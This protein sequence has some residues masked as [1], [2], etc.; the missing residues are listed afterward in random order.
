MNS[1]EAL[2]AKLCPEGVDQKVLSDVATFN[3][4]STI[5]KADADQSG[6][7]PVIAGGRSPAYFH[8]EANRVGPTVVVAGSGA[9][10]GFVSYWEDPV[11]VSDAFS[12]DPDPEI[13]H[14]KYIYYLLRNRQGEIHDL[15]K[16]GGVPHVYGRDLAAFEIGVPPLE[17]QSEI[18]RILDTFAELEAE[19]EAELD[20][21]KKQY[22]YYRDQLLTFPEEGGVRWI[23]MSDLF[24]RNSGTPITAQRM[25]EI[26]SPSGT[27]TVFAAGNTVAQV[28]RDAIPQG[29]IYGGEAIMV[30][31]RG[32]IDFDFVD[33]D[34]TH[35][36]ELWSY[37]S[38][39]DEIN[40]KFVYYFLKN[41]VSE[42]RDLA[43]SK[44]V[45]LPQLAVRDTDDYLV[46]APNRAEQDAIVE[47][48]DKFDALVN[49]ISVGLPA[50]IESRR[51]QYEYYRDKLLTFP[52]AAA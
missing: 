50:E 3:R 44:S 30:K 48:L 51:K 32:H 23:P 36:S 1:I 12:V 9:Y 21:R 34:F 27:I 20:A 45:K 31:S 46:P 24:I 14:P 42:F 33:T 43:K 11:F 4:G 18:V 6:Q 49:G 16:G 15:K 13:A 10:A 40:V 37:S 2:V 26:D 52:E 19:L 41:R 35:K 47:T 28:Q 39:T 22:E 29:A 7:V 17:I 25:R 5:T 38:K 8:S